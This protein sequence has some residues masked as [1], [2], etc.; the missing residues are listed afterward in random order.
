MPTDSKEAVDKL[1]GA[2][3]TAAHSTDTFD[4]VTLDVAAAPA[5]GA[6][7]LQS[8]PTMCDERPAASP[9]GEF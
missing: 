8:F 3:A 4:D 1:E 6:A 9:I 5:D 7:T 2:A